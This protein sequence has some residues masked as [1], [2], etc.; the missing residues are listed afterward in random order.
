MPQYLDE[1]GNPVGQPTYLDDFGNPV[2]SSQSQQPQQNGNFLTR[3][4]VNPVQ[5]PQNIPEWQKLPGEIYNRFIHPMSSPAGA[6]TTGITSVFGVPVLGTIARMMPR[7][8]GAGLGI[9]AGAGAYNAASDVPE[10]ISNPSAKGAVNLAEDAAMIGM[11]PIAK[12]LFWRTPIKATQAAPAIEQ[13]MLPPIGGENRLIR[14]NTGAIDLRQLPP[15]L[16]DLPQPTVFRNPKTSKFERLPPSNVD[17]N[18]VTFT[19]VRPDDISMRDASQAQSIG[20]TTITLHPSQYTVTP[21][22]AKQAAVRATETPFQQEKQGLWQQIVNDSRNLKTIWDFSAPLRQGIF[23]L[24]KDYG[25]S[26][27]KSMDDMIRSVGKSGY[28]AA[29]NNIKTS[30][31]YEFKKDV[32]GIAYTG[33]VGKHEEA[34]NHGWIEKYWPGALKSNRSYEAFTNTLRDN[35]AD[36]L[37]DLATKS[38]FNVKANAPLARAMG[39]FVNNAS[40]R[41][42][43]GKLEKY[44]E[45][46]NNNLFSPRLIASRVRMLNPNNFVQIGHKDMEMLRSFLPEKARRLILDIGNE[47][48][49]FS[50]EAQFMRKEYLKSLSSVAAMGNTFL[51]LAQMAGAEVSYDPAS[52]DFGKAKIGNVRLDPWGGNQQY[53]VFAQRMFPDAFGG[54]TYQSSTNP[55]NRYQ[56]GSAGFGQ[57][58]RLDVATNFAINKLNPP[59][60]IA[61]SWLAQFAN[62]PFSIG[63]EVEGLFLPMALQ[64]M[65]E[66]RRED[67]S[68]IPV[69]APFAT[70]GGGVQTYGGT[71]QNRPFFLP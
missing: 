26:A 37:I 33:P 24:H 8:L 52:A 59:Q 67:P 20:P 30:K 32:M 18:T 6:L 1:N 42:S 36:N 49:M 9:G 47:F 51:Q 3:N 53:L 70:F 55:S 38:G 48:S 25:R 71:E 54:G 50:R 58:N 19:G 16:E 11:A 64:S 7:A 34:I 28:D 2:G 43:L 41:G 14:K 60:R 22:N 29:M 17:P 5:I 62:R 10:F 27:A 45:G 57:Q 21:A 13:R 23:L 46:L 40:G 69:L 39:E 12:N 31:D 61:A 63:K 4:W 68:L 56:L 66:L 44:A 65:M 35:V 15:E